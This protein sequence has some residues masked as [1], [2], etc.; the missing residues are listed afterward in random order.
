MLT[1]SKYLLTTL[2][3]INAAY[4]TVSDRINVS[5]I[6]MGPQPK[7]EV[8]LLSPTLVQHSKQFTSSDNPED[9]AKAFV[10]EQLRVNDREHVAKSK[11]RS[12]ST[13]VTHV[14]LKQLFQGFEAANDNLSV[15]VDVKRFIVAYDDNF[16]HSVD[17][18]KRKLWVDQSAPQFVEPNTVFKALADYIGKPVD[19]A[20]IMVTLCNDADNNNKQHYVLEGIPYA[21]DKVIA[22]RS[23]IHGE[24]ETLQA[25]WGVFINLG[26][27]YFNTHIAANGPQVLSLADWTSDSS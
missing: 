23:Y 16:Y 11:Y 20:K 25:A 17:A 7:Y 5:F 26:D 10:H 4:F 1:N 18:S 12:E 21:Q 19:T 8:I 2:A 22:Q 14:Y 15:H 9:V 3:V 6:R 24:H 27:N 13:G